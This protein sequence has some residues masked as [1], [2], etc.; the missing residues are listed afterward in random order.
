MSLAATQRRETHVRAA[1]ERQRSRQRHAR[2]M[3]IIMQGKGRTRV[4]AGILG[5]LLLVCMGCGLP[6]PGLSKP[7]PLQLQVHILD[8]ANQNSPVAVDVVAIRNKQLVPAIAAL[9]AAQ[10]FQQK[11]QM[12]RDHPDQLTIR[13]WEWVPGQDVQ[14]LKAPMPGGTKQV[15]VFANYATPGA[16]RALLGDHRQFSLTLQQSDFLLQRLK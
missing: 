9:T 4:L 10:W 7:S 16:H 2:N 12:L 3:Q 14:P 5:S 6:A 15:I 11:Q 1:K 13:S 8:I